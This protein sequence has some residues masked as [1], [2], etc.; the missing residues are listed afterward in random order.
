M[1]ATLAA[2][3]A[4]VAG[5]AADTIRIEVGSNKVNGKVYAPHAARVRV[6]IAG[7]TAITADWTNHLTLGDSAGRPVMRWVTK[8]TRRQPDGKTQ[9]WQILQ[10]Y[11][12]ATLAPLGY[13]LSSSA[14]ADVRLTFE[15]Q[16]VR[17]TRKMPTDAEP[18]K[19]D[20]TLSRAGFIASASDLVPMAVG[21][22]PGAVISAPVWG[23]G[24]TDSELRVFTVIGR[25]TFDVEGTPV[26]TWKVEE[27][28]QADGQLTGVWYLTDQAPYMVGGEVPLPN[29]KTQRM[30]EV[31]IDR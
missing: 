8:G 19:V 15:G 17:G 30:T 31:S 5:P 27:R 12:Q 1:V 23:P 13:W 6:R 9:T 18:T 21:L 7:D 2:L 29:G 11:D 24:M 25:A 14:G 3:G 26:E 16:K 22:E 4:L 20:L 10:T 28:K